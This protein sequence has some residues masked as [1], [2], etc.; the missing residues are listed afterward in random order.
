MYLDA[1]ITE[2][3]SLTTTIENGFAVSLYTESYENDPNV[4]EYEWIYIF[5]GIGIHSQRIDIYSPI[6]GSITTVGLNPLVNDHFSGFSVNLFSKTPWIFN[7]PDDP[8]YFF[9]FGGNG[10]PLRFQ[11]K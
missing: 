4:T 2:S 9:I 5:G 3:V 11:L 7:S 6:D 1:W 10:P 8:F